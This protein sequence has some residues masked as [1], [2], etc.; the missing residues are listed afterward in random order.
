[1]SS[2]GIAGRCPKATFN[3]A[4]S[5][6]AKRGPASLLAML[7]GLVRARGIILTIDVIGDMDNN[8]YPQFVSDA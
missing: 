1:M 3:A 4:I 5:G 7:D 6:R 8:Q 2:L